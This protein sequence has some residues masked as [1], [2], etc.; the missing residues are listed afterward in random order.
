[1]DCLDTDLIADTVP[2]YNATLCKGRRCMH[3]PI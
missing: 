2:G 1:M 3:T